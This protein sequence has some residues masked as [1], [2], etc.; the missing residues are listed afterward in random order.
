M[1]ERMKK[2]NL[3]VNQFVNCTSPIVFPSRSTSKCTEIS[4]ICISSSSFNIMRMQSRSTFGPDK[5][6]KSVY[7]FNARDHI[8]FL[9][10]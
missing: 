2:T 6:N 1:E 4:D 7:N 3:R 9:F 8:L 10:F 5:E